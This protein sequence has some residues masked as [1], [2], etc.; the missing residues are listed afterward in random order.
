VTHYEELKWHGNNA[1]KP[2]KLLEDSKKHK[3]RHLPTDL[4]VQQLASLK[5]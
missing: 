3:K 4:W 1:S 5:A 2:K